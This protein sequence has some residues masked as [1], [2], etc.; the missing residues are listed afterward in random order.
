MDTFITIKEME[1]LLVLTLICLHTKI[2]KLHLIL[3]AIK[4]DVL[5]I[6]KHCQQ[7]I[8]KIYPRTFI[9]IKWTSKSAEF[10]YFCMQLNHCY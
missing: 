8:Y 3:N 7:L 6:L 2:L 9:C 1:G 4:V 10:Q 5:H